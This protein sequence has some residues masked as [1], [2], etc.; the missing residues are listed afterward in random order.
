MKR[1]LVP[2]A[3]QLIAAACL[4]LAANAPA[5]L[6]IF[7][8]GSAGSPT[9]TATAL[10]AD[11][12]ASV[13]SGNVGTPTTGSTSPLYSAG[14]GGAYFTANGW[15]GASPGTN[16][17]SFTLQPSPGHEFS[18]T[19]LSF[20]YRTTST[21]PTD[22]VVRS[23][24]DAYAANLIAGILVGD[25]TWHST[26]TLAFTLPGLDEAT[27]FRIMASGASSSLGTFRIDD[28]TLGGAVSAVPEPG[29]YA[30]ILGA[31]VLGVLVLRRR[32]ISRRT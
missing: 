29:T 16:Y 8:F 3:R 2:A 22:F 32:P 12:T 7:S 4:M 11:L 31:A 17:F 18:V 20:G 27:T 1:P 15:T 23:S 24:A 25:S 30:L 5:Q 9:N 13:F 14:S 6:V 26:G 19:S 21:G 28:V 10:D